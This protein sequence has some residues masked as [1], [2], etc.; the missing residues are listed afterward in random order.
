MINN[1]KGV[2]EIYNGVP[3]SGSRV[4]DSPSRVFFMVPVT[5]SPIS[6]FNFSIDRF[7][8]NAIFSWSSYIIRC[9]NK[10][11]IMEQNGRLTINF[12]YTN[13]VV[14]QRN[15]GTKLFIFKNSKNKS[16]SIIE[17]RECFI[18]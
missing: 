9:D 11:K 2:G 4:P 16:R 15:N 14:E 18:I 7:L 1:S 3:G 6:I 5:K 10:G 12:L 8:S 17:K 13:R